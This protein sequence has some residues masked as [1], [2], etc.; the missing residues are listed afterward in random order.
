MI[1]FPT[2]TKPFP[3]PEQE[4]TEDFDSDHALWLGRAK[5]MQVGN[6]MLYPSADGKTKPLKLA[7]VSKEHDRYVFVN[8]RANV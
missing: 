8:R 3:T 4:A 5:L 1:A 2:P 7:W 6:W